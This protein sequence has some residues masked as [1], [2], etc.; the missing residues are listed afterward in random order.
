MTTSE[1][2]QDIPLTAI[3]PSPTNPRKSFD[4]L[5][6]ASLRDNIKLHGLL[7]PVLVRRNLLV[8]RL[9][10][11]KKKTTEY[12]L[13]CGERRYRACEMAGLKTIRAEVRDLSD[14]EVRVIQLIENDQREDVDEIEA[15]EGL[16]ELLELGKPIDELVHVLG[17]T[18]AHLYGSLKLLKI[19]AGEGREA[20]R[21]GRL[22]RN[23][24]ILIGRVPS[25]KL[26]AKLLKQVLHPEG[27]QYGPHGHKA[28]EILSFRELKDLIQK[29]YSREL[30]GAPFDRQALDLVPN[31]GSCEECPKRVGNMP[32]ADEDA[33]ADVC[34]DPVCYGK[35]AVAHR[36]GEE[37]R[38]AEKGIKTIPSAE[39]SKLLNSVYSAVT[40]RFVLLSDVC[41]ADK[42]QRT[43]DQL[44]GK[45]LNGD[46]MAAIDSKGNVHYCVSK[47]VAGELLKKKGIQTPKDPV[48][49]SGHT[50][51]QD[52]KL[53]QQIQDN[54]EKRMMQAMRIEIDKLLGP[55]EGLHSVS[56]TG[57]LRKL[58]ELS[59]RFGTPFEACGID[60]Q[61]LQEGLEKVAGDM[62]GRECLRFL[63]LDAISIRVAWFQ[64]A[65]N[66][67]CDQLCDLMA[68]DKKQLIDLA[69]KEARGELPEPAQGGT[70]AGDEKQ[71]KKRKAKV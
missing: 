58:V 10:K 26:R 7:Q 52:W 31:V 60:R 14:T 30:K 34:T 13:V 55:I 15:A 22:P 9:A 29:D 50:P 28:G 69:E 11:G 71:T 23:H 43:Y 40:S 8:D 36:R 17:K 42:K 27:Y 20:L 48:V 45:Q 4:A 47:D 16:Q 64:M 1:T 3:A 41:R 62:T 54:I 59:D 44:I 24:A 19:P 49:T 6:L 67:D 25:E 51:K 18:K 53:E 66:E 38:L 33:R 39:T 57:V 5:K 12:E 35:K 21:S 56:L 61:E 65:D 2:S 63:L 46:K 37:K 70:D 68:I 32:D